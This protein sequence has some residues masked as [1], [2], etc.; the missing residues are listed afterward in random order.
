MKTVYTVKEASE[1]MD[2]KIRAIQTRCKNERIAQRNRKYVITDAVINRWKQK[3]KD[4]LNAKQTQ[5]KT[6]VSAN[7]NAKVRPLHIELQAENN[8]LRNRLQ[9]LAESNTSIVK[10]LKALNDEVSRLRGDVRIHKVETEMETEVDTIKSDWN[11]PLNEALQE[12]LRKQ[13]KVGVK[14]ISTTKELPN[15]NRMNDIDFKS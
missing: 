3:Y 9:A 6:I 13:F 12:K 2:I 4:N 15:T 5:L 1:L 8:I 11:N 14:H 10:V 7:A